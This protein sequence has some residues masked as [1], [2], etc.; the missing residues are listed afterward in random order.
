M[1]ASISEETIKWLE[2]LQE[3]EAPISKYDTSDP[4]D[5][6]IYEKGLR[7]QQ[8]HFHPEYDFMLIVLNNGKVLQESLSKYPHL[9]SATATQLHTYHLLGE[10]TGVHWPEIDED[11]SL[12]GLLVSELEEIL[13]KG[14]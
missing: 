10:G 4:I 2:S 3:G 11:L 14:K 9:S 7:I 1:K 12:R 8:I 13:G 6:L 5:S